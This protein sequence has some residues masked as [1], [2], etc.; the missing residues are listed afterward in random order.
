[1]ADQYRKNIPVPQMKPMKDIYHD[2]VPTNVRMLGEYALGRKEPI[3]E[4][5]FTHEEL[6]AIV[7][8]HTK[9]K[10]DNDTKLRMLKQK[11]YDDTEARAYFDRHGGDWELVQN[12]ES[13]NPMNMIGQRQNLDGYLK[14]HREKYEDSVKSLE[15]NPSRVS[16]QYKDSMG[17]QAAPIHQSWIEAAKRSFTD[18][19]FNV[20]STLGAF[21]TYDEGDKIRVEDNYKFDNSAFYHTN[22]LNLGQILQK[23]INSPGSLL[24]MMMIKYGRQ[25][26]LPVNFMIDKPQ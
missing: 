1:M 14:A 24:D 25:D 17:V 22:Q 12:P 11:P 2:V 5:D 19:K 7:D 23:G 4:K 20:A 18:P 6:Q 13:A 21:D 8:M 15:K 3:T 16:L 9:K 10:I 26:P